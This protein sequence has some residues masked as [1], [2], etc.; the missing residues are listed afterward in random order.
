MVRFCV[1]KQLF[2]K[3]TCLRVRIDRQC[4]SLV[5]HLILCRPWLPSCSLPFYASR[6]YK[7]AVGEEGQ[8]RMQ[9]RS[10]ASATRCKLFTPTTY[11][12]T[13]SINPWITISSG[14]LLSS[15]K[16]DNDRSTVIFCPPPSATSSWGQSR[17]IF[18]K[19]SELF[20]PKPT[21]ESTFKKKKKKEP[22]VWLGFDNPKSWG[23]ALYLSGTGGMYDS[24]LKIMQHCEEAHAREISRRMGIEFKSM[25][26]RK[27][28][29]NSKVFFYFISY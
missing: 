2:F 6:K 14:H 18:R 20:P 17:S 25:T 9:L 28:P 29:I 23:G 22:R 13:T 21:P 19:L 26:L 10:R 27:D 8:Q 7:L 1:Y 15:L 3:L 12:T 5:H 4:H 24:F 16:L 11:A